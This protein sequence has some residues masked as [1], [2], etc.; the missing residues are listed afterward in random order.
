MQHI[1]LNI[2][3]E[4]TAHK[5]YVLAAKAAAS[6]VV[7]SAV[8]DL[9]RDM[10]AI[11]LKN[12][13]SLLKKDDE[14]QV[15]A[16]QMISQHE[17]GNGSANSGIPWLSEIIGSLHKDRKVGWAAVIAWARYVDVVGRH[18]HLLSYVASLYA[19]RMDHP[20]RD[21]PGWLEA[22]DEARARAIEACDDAV[23]KAKGGDASV[24]EAALACME[25][26]QEV[27]V[28]LHTPIVV[29]KSKQ[30]RQHRNEL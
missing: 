8:S 24:A 20:M 12:I 13:F 17:P 21:E 28:E 18:R 5:F 19:Q 10:A 3:D 29:P 22:V 9:D 30:G 25:F 14:A 6:Q 11:V 15:V 4:Q 2:L 26:D 16:M 23:A 27:L 1:N 7:D